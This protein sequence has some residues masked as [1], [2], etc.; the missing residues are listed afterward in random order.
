MPQP[1][2]V[3]Q[4]AD[5]FEY[6]Q[7]GDSDDSDDNPLRTDSED[8]AMGETLTVAE[9]KRKDDLQENFTRQVQG[10]EVMMVMALLG[11]DPKSH[12][13]E[14]KQAVRR[15]VSELYSPPRVTAMLRRMT[16]HGLMPGLALDL[17]TNDPDDGSPW[18]FDLPAKREKA[19]KL[20]RTQKPLFVIGS[21]MCT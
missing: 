21:P 5:T 12:R 13:R 6:Q 9:I 20:L 15:I 14:K 8:E 1:A 19:L 3:K 11:A 2:D 16:D 4:E 10:D 17:T 7:A 18:N